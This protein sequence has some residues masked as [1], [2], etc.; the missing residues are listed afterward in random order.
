MNIVM[1]SDL[2][3]AGSGYFN[4]A[5]PI[6]A[7]LTE[8]GHD[9]KAIGLRYNGEEHHYPFSILPSADI[10][11]SM[12]VAQNLYNVWGFDV[13]MVALD[14]PIQDKIIQMMQNRPFK[15]V[16]IMPIEADPLC[17][18]WAMSLMQMDI[19]Y[20][21]SKFG[22]QEAQNAGVYNA[23]YLDVG[24]DT[25]LWKQRTEEDKLAARNKFGFSEDD[26]IVLTIA[27]NQER[28]N[29]SKG[30]EIFAKFRKQAPNA[31]YV[32]VTREHLAVG[33]KLRDYG[34]ELRINKEFT[35][36]ERGFPFEDLWDIYAM[37]DAFLLPSKA[38]GLCLPILEAQAVGVPV[39][40]TNC[41]SISEHLD[42]G[43]GFPVDVEYEY[44]DPFGNGFRYFIDADDGVK[45]LDKIRSGLLLEQTV[46]LARQYVESKDWTETIDGLENDI[47]EIL[48]E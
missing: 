23:K 25:E 36:Y 12:I 8:R 32:L 18:S 43:R 29:L 34:T 16:G 24:L 21:I 1:L 42:A 28:K 45:Q 7:G 27:D 33:W 37:S 46:Q 38:E 15:W 40:A 41:T 9:V 19:P 2:S 14:I 17:T 6:A 4:I 48:P 11:D 35:I 30:M 5:V 10:R 3:M 20:I 47:M 44:R 26:F 22:F 13:F 31:K 39:V